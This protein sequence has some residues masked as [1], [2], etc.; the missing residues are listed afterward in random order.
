[1]GSITRFGGREN[2]GNIEEWRM[3]FLQHWGQKSDS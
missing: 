1:M 2:T 3:E